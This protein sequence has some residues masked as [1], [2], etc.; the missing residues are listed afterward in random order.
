MTAADENGATIGAV[1]KGMPESPSGIDSD[2]LN[3]DAVARDEVEN[4][5]GDVR[6]PFDFAI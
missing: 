3:S 1:W 4:A 5:A 6:H 2:C